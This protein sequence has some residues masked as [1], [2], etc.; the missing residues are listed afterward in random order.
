MSE[1][2]TLT[3][4][5]ITP[6]QWGQFLCT[7]FDE[8]V[9]NDVGSVFVQLFDATLA[10][11]VGVAPGICTLAKSCGHAGV[12][13]YNG[14]VY[15]CDHFVFPEHKLGNLHEKTITEM[16]YSPQQQQFA[17]I[18]QQMLPR[19]CRECRYLFAC[20][21]ECPKNRFLRDH[22][23]DPGLNYL[24]EGYRQFFQHVAPYMEF[25]KRELE[26]GRPPANIMKAL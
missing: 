24:C 8:W 20:N 21:G 22:Y 25:M 9:R 19:Q 3:N 4:S 10:N 7:L 23:G 17:R 16:M 11:W 13:E 26:A 14:D 6:R 2:G 12:M 18:K 15:S 1:G 5:S